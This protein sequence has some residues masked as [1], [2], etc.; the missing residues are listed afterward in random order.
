MD[1][2]NFLKTFPSYK[3]EITLIFI[4]ENNSE[5]K[6]ICKYCGHISKNLSGLNYHINVK[7]LKITKVKI[8]YKL[9][10]ICNKEI[11]IGS[12]NKHIIKCK[13]KQIKNNKS[14]YCEK[15]GKFVTKKYGSGRFCSQKCANSR[16]LSKETKQKISNAVKKNPSG[17]NSLKSRLN[18]KQNF[19]KRK[20][21]YYKNP[22]KCKICGKILDYKRKN[23]KTCSSKKCLH[24]INVKNGGYK[25]HSRKGNAGYYK[26]IYCDSTYELIF[27]IYCLDHNIL[28]KRNKKYFLYNYNNKVHKYYP[29][30]I[31]NNRMLIEIKNFYSDIAEAKLKATTDPIKVLY[32]KDLIKI[33]KYVSNKY[34][35]PLII[36]RDKPLANFKLLYDK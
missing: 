34:N 18:K 26:G 33:A 25:K 30:F 9:C 6:Y 5:N 14:Y 23:A 29:D 17:W 35:I 31:I 27:L 2:G 10:N 4:M 8:K 15:C 20:Q 13:Q 32:G 7:H 21:E 24:I 3:T 16:I 11:W 22:N 28:I 12:Y 1:L 19:E 36:K